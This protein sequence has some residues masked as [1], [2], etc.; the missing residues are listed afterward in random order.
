MMK[1][2]KRLFLLCLCV[3]LLGGSALAN[4]AADYSVEGYD[5]LYYKTTMPDGRLVFTGSIGEP[6]NYMDSRARILCL[7]P[8]MTVS[9]EYI[10]PAE[11]CCRF[12]DAAFLKDGTL[13]VLFEDS[14][15]QTTEE[16]KLKF[17]TAEGRL[18]GKEIPLDS[19]SEYSVLPSGLLTEYWIG[20]KS[21]SYVELTDWEG[22]VRFRWQGYG[23][24]AWEN[25]IEE[26]DGLVL[27]GREAGILENAAGMIMK[28]DWQGNTVW[29]TV[30]PFLKE[31]NEGAGL[32][33]CRT[34]DGCYLAVLGERGL[35]DGPVDSEWTMAL[36][37]FSPQGRILWI[38]T[39]SLETI[40]SDYL[41]SEAVEYNGKYVIQCEHKNRF[42]SLSYPIRYLWFDT[43]GKALGTTEM[44]IRKEDFARLADKRK[45]EAILGKLIPAGNGLWQVFACWD[46]SNNHEKE[47]TSTDE[48]FL[49]VPE[50]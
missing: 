31:E 15:F 7:N 33:G 41:F 6:G 2:L 46:E 21:E 4:E 23:P 40:S 38:S 28:V 17:F 32:N 25:L 39:E 27:I 22:K 19:S 11:G 13:G 16:I 29:E 49:K 14:P 9:W 30:V 37:K 8:D 26:E 20:K 47:M 18:T 36:V 34:S 43:D 42:G 48:V 5:D 35:N 12:G 3:A 1:I 10:D 24:M 50:L 45:V 44:N